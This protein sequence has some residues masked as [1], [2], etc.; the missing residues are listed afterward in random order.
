MNKGKLVGFQKIKIVQLQDLDFTYEYDGELFAKG[1]EVGEE[2]RNYYL[3]TIK[4]FDGSIGYEGIIADSQGEA[5]YNA[6][7]LAKESGNVLSVEHIKKF[8]K[9]GMTEHGLKTG[10]KI[11]SGKA[12]GTTIIVEDTYGKRAKVDLN[13]GKRIGLEYDSKLKKY[14]EKK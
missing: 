13:S 14:I 1:G 11:I 7:L 9:G 12:I 2:E 5:E 4:M 3:A 6:D 10:D 8:A